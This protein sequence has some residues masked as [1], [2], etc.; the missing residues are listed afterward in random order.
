MG[1]EIVFPAAGFI[2]MAVEALY[3]TSQSIDLTK[4]N[5][6]GKYRYR[7][8]NVRFSKALVLEENAQCKTMLTLAPCPGSNNPWHEFKI[9]SLTEDV[10]TEHS[11]GMIRLE[12]DVEEGK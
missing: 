1:H 9:S 10:W 5:Q 8:L 4:G 11:R 6:A 7:L 3:Q 12:K 2:A